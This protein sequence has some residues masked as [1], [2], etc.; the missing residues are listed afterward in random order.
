MKHEKRGPEAIKIA[1]LFHMSH[2]HIGRLSYRHHAH[3]GT[4]PAHRFSCSPGGYK[5]CLPSRLFPLPRRQTDVKLRGLLYI[6]KGV[7]EG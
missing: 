6:E 1:A 3:I 4:V 7:L 5:F 2:C